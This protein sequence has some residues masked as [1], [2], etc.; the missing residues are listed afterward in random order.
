MLLFAENMG[1]DLTVQ[2]SNNNND[3]NSFYLVHQLHNC[4]LKQS[5]ATGFGLFVLGH[6]QALYQV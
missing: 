3:S 6:H 5:K 2:I 1:Y 4:K